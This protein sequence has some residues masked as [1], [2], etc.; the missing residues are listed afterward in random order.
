[1]E[2]KVTHQEFDLPE[3]HHHLMNE[4]SH[5]SSSNEG[6]ATNSSPESLRESDIKV[7]EKPIYNSIKRKLN[8]RF[9]PV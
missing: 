9:A 5:S 6:A 1:M 4:E 3:K 7:E 8:E 2:S